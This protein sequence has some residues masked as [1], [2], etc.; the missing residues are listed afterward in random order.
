[1][2]EMGRGGEGRKRGMEK[3]RERERNK[4]IGKL[5]SKRE[6]LVIATSI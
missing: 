5:E 1:M 2:K 3:E 6:T 4:E